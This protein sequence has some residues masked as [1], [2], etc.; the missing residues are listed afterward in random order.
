MVGLRHITTQLSAPDA[1]LTGLSDVVVM[2]SAQGPRIYTV[3][4]S[5]GGVLV[6]DPKGGLTVLD[7]AA[8]PR[9]SA[10]MDAPTQLLV[11][12]YNG[13]PA[14][15]SVGQYG[16]VVTVFPL[17]S[18][19]MI[20]TPRALTLSG[21]GVV[22]A[23]ALAIETVTFGDH[24]FVL[25]AS[26]QVE[27]LTVWEPGA[28]YTLTPV[29]QPASVGILPAGGVSALAQFTSG[30][31]HC[32]LALSAQDEGLFNYQMAADGTLTLA[33]RIDARDGLAIGIGTQL[34]TVTLAGQSYALVGAAGSSTLSVIAL[35][36]D[37]HMTVA[38]QVIDELT[39]RFAGLTELTSLTVDGQVYIAVAGS[40]NG[41]TLMTLLPG[42]RLVQLATLADDNAMALTNPSGLALGWSADGLDLFVTSG[43]PT[44]T[45]GGGV[46]QLRGDLGPIGITVQLGAGGAVQTG[47]AGRDQIA[48]GSG[49]DRLDGGAGDDIL[50]DGAGTDTLTGGAG[51]DIFVLNLDGQE[52][53]ITDFQPGTDRLDLADLGRFYT[54]DAIGF[55]STNSG[56]QIRIGAEVVIIDTADGRP[57]T[58][59]DLQISDLRDLAH[60]IVAPLD[61]AASLLNGGVAADFLD[62]RGGADSLIGGGGGDTLV[63][64]D[65]DDWLIG[66]T[67]LAGPDGISG[68]V[69]RLYCT[70][71]NR[72]PD[73]AG[74][75]HWSAALTAGTRNLTEVTSG[76]V[77]SAEF[78][79]TYANLDNS[80]FVT[81]LYAN[82]LHRA[83]DAAGLANWTKLLD[84][85][86]RSR[87]QVVVGFSESTEFRQTS[88]AGAL[89]FSHE[90]VQMG[91]SDDV[92]RLYHATLSRDPDLA[93]FLNWTGKLA[94]TLPFASVIS[95]FVNSAEF[96][97][98]YGQTSDQEFVT[99]LYAN[100]LGRAPDAAGLTNWLNLLATGARSRE[101]VVEGFAQSREFIVNSAQPLH[102]W[103]TSSGQDDLLDAGSGNNVLF[104]GMLS[105]TFVFHADTEC[106]DRVIG[107]ESWDVLSFQGFGYDA[108]SDLAA[109]LRQDEANVVFSDQGVVVTFE[110]TALSSVLAADQLF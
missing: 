82:V 25:L 98:T 63:G 108:P 83:P 90:G 94:D 99:L 66:G 102:D 53:R 110:Q 106:S 86:A 60:T 89:A 88:A 3:S 75:L 32:V 40:D 101:Q 43:V 8:F 85:G 42:G 15:Y 96:R 35:G 28:K 95:G 22:S 36:P 79:A 61:A 26:R 92:F 44:G 104:G 17:D 47:T 105:D 7:Q 23:A 46:T 103:M 62:G 12:T 78:R 20:T 72:A 6:L 76:F 71:L 68:Q 24:S 54:M 80:G 21:T 30:N 39:T 65:G 41:V 74:L 93:G 91:Y 84:S 37:G 50:T 18:S 33:G 55:T 4:A 69:Y 9:S 58:L 1:F 109:H 48:G 52:D 31:Q 70:T 77:N 27:G 2:T 97:A 29:A 87:E 100:V 81:L 107:F 11:A 64:N 38:D 16:R 45:A 19:G 10:G 34:E 14:L 56:A 51:A 67:P 5:G 13:A 73:M 57:L 49:A 59:A